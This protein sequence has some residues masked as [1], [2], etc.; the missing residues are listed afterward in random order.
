MERRSISITFCLH[1]TSQI[2]LPTIYIQNTFISI[3]QVDENIK[4]LKVLIKQKTTKKSTKDT[5]QDLVFNFTMSTKK[6][7]Q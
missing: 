3:L 1:N 5:M 4:C 7:I 2:H 6:C